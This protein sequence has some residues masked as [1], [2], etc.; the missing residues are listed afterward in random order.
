MKLMKKVWKDVEGERCMKGKDRK[1]SFVEKDRKRILKNHVEE[2]M[3]KE[4]DWDH[5]TEPNMVE[6]HIE[7][8]SQ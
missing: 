5:M 1:L 8:V 7:K 3:N 4:N 6:G 2:I